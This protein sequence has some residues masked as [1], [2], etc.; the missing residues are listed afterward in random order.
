VCGDRA[1]N[2]AALEVRWWWQEERGRVVGHFVPDGRHSGYAGIMHGGLLSALLDECL[3][4]ACAV[5]RR[6]YCVT[7]ELT[8]RFKR[9][10]ALGD[11]LEISG[12]SAARWGRY[13]KAEGEVRAGDGTLLATVTATFSA[14]PREQAEALREALR[15][16][17]GDLD[18]LAPADGAGPGTPGR[19]ASRPAG[20]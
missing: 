16:E 5:E 7:G 20:E 14:M 18:I 13:Q 19:R 4:W 11:R 10:A 8:V 17:P 1:I 2:P 9:P 12:W 3:A 15:F 6:S